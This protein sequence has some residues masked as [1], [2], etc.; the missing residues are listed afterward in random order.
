M[1]PYPGYEHIHINQE[2]DEKYLAGWYF[3]DTENQYYHGPFETI[4][5]TL[6]A[7]KFVTEELG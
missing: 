2:S 5:E 6:E 3:F 7:Y 4:E 1:K